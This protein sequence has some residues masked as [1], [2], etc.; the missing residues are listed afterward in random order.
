MISTKKLIEGKEY[1]IID[2]QNEW[3]ITAPNSTYLEDDDS[4]IPNVHPI[5]L[6]ATGVNTLS[7]TGYVNGH[8][9]WVIEYDIDFNYFVG[10]Y[11]VI[12]D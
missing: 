12:D 8:P 4:H 6:T 10:T 5:T 9:N 11:T 1:T 7:K 3:E 2:F